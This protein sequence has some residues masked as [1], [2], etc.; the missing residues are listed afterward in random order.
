MNNILYGVI[1][2]I[3]IQCRIHTFNYCYVLVLSL[4]YNIVY[5]A[6]D[7]TVQPREV[8][9]LVELV[10]P[11]EWEGSPIQG[12]GQVKVFWS[13]VQPIRHASQELRYMFRFSSKELSGRNI[14]VHIMTTIVKSSSFSSL[15]SIDC[16]E[17][18]L[19]PVLDSELWN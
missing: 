2:D 15:L 13:H 9:F 7:L 1:D 19:G 8:D 11:Q 4:V 12:Q 17:G 5:H 18:T 16:R 3:Y 10:L 14:S 6:F